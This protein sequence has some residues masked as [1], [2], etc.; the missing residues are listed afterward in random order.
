MIITLVLCHQARSSAYTLTRHKRVHAVE[1][2]QNTSTLRR[3]QS[4]ST[5]AL[6]VSMVPDTKREAQR[7][8][9]RTIPAP[10]TERSSLLCRP[11]KN[12]ARHPHGGVCRNPFL[13]GHNTGCDTGWVR[14]EGVLVETGL[15]K[16]EV[17]KLSCCINSVNLLMVRLLLSLYACAPLHADANGKSLE[18]MFKLMRCSVWAQSPFFSFAVKK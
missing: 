8:S 18:E 13:R 17:V 10:H 9:R 1:S 4:W 7:R 11:I 5:S 3:T 14:Y 6:D 12:G 16:M 2:V 15:C